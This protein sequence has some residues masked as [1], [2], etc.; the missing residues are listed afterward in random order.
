VIL[1]PTKGWVIHV[2][3]VPSAGIDFGEA[4]AFLCR[5][6]YD[7]VFGCDDGMRTMTTAR[8]AAGHSFISIKVTLLTTL[9]NS[10]SFCRR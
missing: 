8:L 3:F 4:K 10:K 1:A 7:G 2:L 5:I 9:V 6:E